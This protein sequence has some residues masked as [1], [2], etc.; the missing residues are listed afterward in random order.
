MINGS[1]HWG[2]D[3][4]INKCISSEQQSSP[5]VYQFQNQLC[6]KLVGPNVHAQATEMRSSRNEMATSGDW[7]A[8]K[9]RGDPDQPFW[10]GKTLPKSEWGNQYICKNDSHG[11]MTIEGGVALQLMS[12]GIPRRCLERMQNHLFRATKIWLLQ[13]LTRIYTKCTGHELMS[14][15]NVWYNLVE[16]MIL[17]IVKELEAQCK[18]LKENGIGRNMAMYGGWMMPCRMRL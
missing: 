6:T 7:V 16:W 4:Q 3:C 13:D 1:L 9:S 17:S 5:T 14:Q 18:L 10:I 12:S 15:D 8:Y 2:A 11:N